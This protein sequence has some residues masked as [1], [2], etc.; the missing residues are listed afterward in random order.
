MR[1]ICLFTLILCSGIPGMAQLVNKAYNNQRNGSMPGAEKEIVAEE[2]T[3]AIT[4]KVIY[5][6]IPD[7]YHVTYTKSFIGKSVADVEQ[8]MNRKA[9]SLIRAAR[10]LSI[11]E[12]DIVVDIVSLDPI[13]NFNQN[14]STLNIPL[15]YKISEN[16]TFNIKTIDAIREL[17]HT[18]L[19][20]GIYDM[21]GAQAYLEDSKK[22][23]DSLSAKAVQVLDMK[24][25]LCTQIGWAFT[26][27][28]V[29]FTKTK[30]VYYPSERYLNAYITNAG[31]YKHHLSQNSTIRME[32]TVDVD[33]YYD[34]NLK[35]ADFV[36]NA[37][38]TCPVIQFYYQL[39]YSYNKVDTEEEMRNKI[40]KEMETKKD[41]VFYMIDKN[42]VLKKIEL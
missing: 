29:T 30:D 13:F 7:G 24:K 41:P 18:C 1:T 34:M 40:K 4:T 38:K 37:S 42:G 2:N 9:D 11:S 6:A 5:N 16:I 21:I 32:R 26:G 19:E 20:Y 17:S 36:F 15:G 22:I 12:K 10:K 25:K 33:N 31:L 8:Q 23:Y 14:D 28:K 39:N 3:I 27:G 35:D